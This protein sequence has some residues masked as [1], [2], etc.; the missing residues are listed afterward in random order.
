VETSLLDPAGKRLLEELQ[1]N[2]RLSYAAL[3][4]R[5]GLSATATAE[6]MRRMEEAGI[7]RRYTID[8]EPEALGLP[9]LAL[10]RM[11]CD[12]THYQ[13][14]LKYVKSLSEVRECHHLTGGDAFI[15]KIT[16]SSIASLERIIERLL[17]YG[18]PTTSVVLSSPLTRR[19]YTFERGR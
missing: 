15:L 5:V 6:R 1:Q 7:I 2:A 11:T 8:V 12:G 19:A 9:V 18:I 14:F 4:R 17:P 10:I 16:T 13:P 3:G